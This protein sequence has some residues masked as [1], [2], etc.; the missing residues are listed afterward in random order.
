[1]GWVFV[2]HASA[3]LA[4]A[5]ALANALQDLGVVAWLAPDRIPPG[6]DYAKEIAE[7]IAQSSC[8]VMLLSDDSLAS[9][10]VRREVDAAIGAGT[11]LLP[12]D[13]TGEH[14]LA[15]LPPLW[16]Y[17]LR[18][19]QYMVWGGAEATATHI[20]GALDVA[21]GA[22]AADH[23]PQAVKPVPR[24]PVYV[25]D[26]N[27]IVV[28]S[29]LVASRLSEVLADLGDR[30][31]MVSAPWSS[32]LLQ[33]LAD[34][35]LDMCVYNEQAVVAF[36]TEHPG[37]LT[38]V[39]HACY[40]M[41][42]H[43]FALLARAGSHWE[44]VS[45]DT[46]PDALTQ[47]MRVYVGLDT[48]RWPSFLRV[49]GLSHEELVRRGVTLVNTPE[50]GP[51]I[52]AADPEAL[53]VGGQNARFEALSGGG[54]CE[55]IDYSSLPEDARARLR[56]A[57]SNVLVVRSGAVEEHGWDLHRLNKRLRANLAEA[58]IDEE[59]LDD[60][61]REL[62]RTCGF[63]VAGRRQRDRITRHVLYETYRAGRLIL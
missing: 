40:S 16:Q 25:A 38:V 52:L 24:E 58:W 43:N 19:V 15:A 41:G 32:G 7:A 33:Q 31:A 37:I 23:S 12:V 61:V 1:M 29:Y 4:K 35:D 51:Q 54:A 34:G 8:V 3:D 46:L 18:V 28:K 27:L 53:L 44:N 11:R 30:V 57:S 63:E 21:Q 60:V 10:Q 26:S 9:T 59:E 45:V 20:A 47:G 13:L 17:L 5:R 56:L 50:P 42:G 36:A 39:G 22:I 48:D 6:A 55:V 62:T 49:V 2:S 14:P